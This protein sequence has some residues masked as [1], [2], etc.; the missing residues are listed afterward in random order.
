MLTKGVILQEK[1]VME[2]V[3]KK[4]KFMISLHYIKVYRQLCILLQIIFNYINL[5]PGKIDV[6]LSGIFCLVWIICIM[7]FL[8]KIK[9]NVFL[10]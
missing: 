1:W 2:M 3:Q 8:V 9:Q 7:I 6:F 4:E 10:I 5:F